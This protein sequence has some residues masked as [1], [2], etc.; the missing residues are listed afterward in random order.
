[1]VRELRGTPGIDVAA[2][3]SRSP[4][5]D[6]RRYG[7]RTAPTVILLDV[8]GNERERFEG[9][10]SSTIASLRCALDALRRSPTAEARTP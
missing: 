5:D 8:A 6:A 2:I 10:S 7:V 1:M 4:G 3:D 9:E